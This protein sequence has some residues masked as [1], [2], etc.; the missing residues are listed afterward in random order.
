MDWLACRAS[1][2]AHAVVRF[3]AEPARP[4]RTAATSID[5]VPDLGAQIGSLDW[6]RGVATCTALCVAT[7]ALAPG[8]KPLVGAVPPPLAGAEW[9]EARA[10]GSPRSAKVRRP[11]G[12]WPP[13]TSSRR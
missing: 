9:D 5:W 11:A 10:R 4:L 1:R 8:I 6:W 7:W 2:P 12:E 13:M 3:N